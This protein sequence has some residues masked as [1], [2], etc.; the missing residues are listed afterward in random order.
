MYI[1][2]KVIS[3]NGKV[4][5]HRKYAHHAFINKDVIQVELHY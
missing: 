4:I 3:N 2:Y 5:R 1:V